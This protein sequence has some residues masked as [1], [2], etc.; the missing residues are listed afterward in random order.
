MT[1]MKNTISR[2]HLLEIGL[3]V[4]AATAAWAA[5]GYPVRET[6]F[7]SFDPSFDDLFVNS[8]KP[9]GSPNVPGPLVDRIASGF[10]WAEGPVWYEDSVLFVDP[11][12]NSIFEIKEHAWGHES[13]IYDY[14]SHYPLDLPAP[15]TAVGYGPNGLGVDN[16]GR[17]IVAEHT[18]R[19][20]ARREANGTK[21]I[22]ASR[23]DGKR[24]NS[25]N[26][27]VVRRSDG[28]IYGMAASRT[29]RHGRK[30]RRLS[31]LPASGTP[32]GRACRFHPARS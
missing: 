4:S 17:L 29:R 5:D 11:R 22:L 14:A 27:F 12:L 18:L 21:T 23:W 20:V 6:S 25:P 1:N 24:L 7:V 26:D 8:P 13:N 16:Q 32:R 30:G 15:Q 10:R 28:S 31:A 2:R 3:A 19:Q 9:A